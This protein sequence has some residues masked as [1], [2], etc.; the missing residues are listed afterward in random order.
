VLVGGVT[1]VDGEVGT[2]GLSVFGDSSSPTHPRPNIIPGGMACSIRF[3][4][5]S[6]PRGPSCAAKRARLRG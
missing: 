5:T 4:A 1:D 3:D 2:G 6:Q